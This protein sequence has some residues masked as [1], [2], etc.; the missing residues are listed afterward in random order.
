M[1]SKYG[2]IGIVALIVVVVGAFLII[3]EANEGPFEEA[4][5]DMEDAAEDM[6]DE[7][8]Q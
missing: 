2:I 6:A 8:D 5:E 7:F 1:N 3:D 4:A